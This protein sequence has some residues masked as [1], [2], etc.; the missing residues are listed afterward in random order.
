MLLSQQ[1]FY[2][3]IGAGV[4]FG[5]PAFWLFSRAMWPRMAERSR[6][7]ASRGLLLNFFLGVPVV[8][9]VIMLGTA[10]GRRGQVGGLLAIG[11]G[12]LVLVWGLAGLTGL[13][14]H[15]GSRLWPACRDDDAWR[16]LWRGGLVISGVLAIPFIG[17]YVLILV[18]LTTGLGIRVRLWFMKEVKT[19]EAPASM[20]AMASTTPP[21]PL[22]ESV[23]APAP[24]LTRTVA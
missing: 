9:L 21:M 2:L 12:G 16:A 8:A 17:W 19:Q 7:A 20:P 1:F 14:Q 23:T 15:V 3:L 13:A 6:E 5:L 24:P 10:A 18:L 4:L 22:Q 11:L